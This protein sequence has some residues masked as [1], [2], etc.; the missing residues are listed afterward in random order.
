MRAT[1]ERAQLVCRI[2]GLRP[3][4]PAKHYQRCG[5]DN[6]PRHRIPDSMDHSSLGIEGFFDRP[7]IHEH[8]HKHR[9]QTT[10]ELKYTNEWTRRA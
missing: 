8:V 1:L 3:A 4:A 9:L 2:P 6:D 10:D 5:Q 7:D